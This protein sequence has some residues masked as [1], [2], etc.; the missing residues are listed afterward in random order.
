MTI[1]QRVFKSFTNGPVYLILFGLVFFGIGAG[2]T[3][4][5]LQLG[6]Q[7]VEV[8]GQVVSLSTNCDSD[9]CSYSPIVRFTTR[10]G[11]T[12]TFESK[13]SS[14]PP[15]YDVGEVVTVIYATEN[16]ENAIIKGEGQVLRIV[17]MSVGGT[18][19]AVGFYLFGSNFGAAPSVA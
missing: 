10:N 5:Q 9:G 1:L 18:I 4:H 16:S 8:S 19:M 11:Q 3:Y 13:F 6:H 12:I 7:G 17:F 2:L 15:S 14:S